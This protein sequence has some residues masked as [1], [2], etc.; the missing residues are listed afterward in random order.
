MIS[1]SS[2]GCVLGVVL[3]GG[4]SSRMG[5]DKASMPHSLGESY[6]Q[7][8][9]NR[10]AA[11]CEDVIVS[12]ETHVSHDRVSVVDEVK[13]QGPV[14]GIL[15][16]LQYAKLHGFDGC[17]VTPVDTPNLS[18]EDLQSLLAHWNKRR[19]L[20]LAQS[21]WIQPLIGIYGFNELQSLQELAAT[22]DRSLMRWIK[23]R[24]V[25]TVTLTLQA[26][27]NIN[28]PEDLTNAS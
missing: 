17:L 27:R 24:N 1:E 2:R 13:N 15:A 4:K 16:S 7:V 11:V 5:R 6:L 10:L 23:P 21:D 18:V 8:A 3:C 25:Q 14:M 28:T 12:G 19:E 26:C 22:N 9:I 20:T